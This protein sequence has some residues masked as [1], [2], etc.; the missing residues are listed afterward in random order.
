MPSDARVQ[1]A[2]HA[3]RH[4]LA[5]Y[6]SYTAAARERVR[7]LLASDGGADRA[8]LEL[9]PF[10][11][12]IDATRF[13]E[14]RHGVVLDSLS[15]ARLERAAAVLAELDG[16]SDEMFVVDVPAGDSLRVVVAHALARAGRAFGAAAV[17]ELVRGA[18]Y[19]P[20]RHDR[21]L[22]T[23]PVEWWGTSERDHAPPLI[24]TVQGAD[25]RAGSLAE[26]L[27]GSLQLIFLVRGPSTPA[28]L[29][30]L[31]TPGVLV[32]QARDAT[33]L[34]V[35]SDFDG[36][37]VVAVFEQE[38]A[39]FTHLPTT[40]S[41]PW[42]RL[43]VA[44]RPVAPKKS[45]AGVSPRQQAEELMLLDALKE[46]PALPDAPV[47]A[48][49]PSGTGDPADRLTAWLLAASGLANDS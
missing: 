6:R 21:L 18:R 24:V 26:L 31:A 42:Q 10:G 33:A 9:G 28:P 48:L 29:V 12:R 19:E 14:L 38:A 41:A 40:G 8:R 2:L 35:V 34:D 46:R 30:R 16:A 23:C 45:V 37:A 43:T 17:A 36:P 11:A 39:V 20:E 27:D 4:R 47:E 3:L 49:V 1:L 32:V 7:T 44:H 22:E 5:A 25:L 15:R 13:A